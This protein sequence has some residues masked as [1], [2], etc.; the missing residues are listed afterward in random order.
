MNERQIENLDGVAVAR[1]G[2]YFVVFSA[3]AQLKTLY[4]RKQAELYFSQASK[5]N[6]LLTG[7]ATQYPL[8]FTFSP[9]FRTIATNE[10]ID[11]WIYTKWYLRR[12]EKK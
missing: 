7:S 2:S 8:Y 9:H 4:A 12:E 10:P 5:L 3:H 1:F 11:K 6:T